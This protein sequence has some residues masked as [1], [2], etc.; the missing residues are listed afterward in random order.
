MIEQLANSGPLPALEMAIRFAAGRQRVIAHNI[1]NISTPNFQPT[2]V[3]PRAF[4][5]VLGEAIDARRGRTGGLD[6]DLTWSATREIAPAGRSTSRGRSSDALELTAR[7]DSDGVLVHDR[8][9]RDVERL[10]Q[11]NAENAAVFRV[12]TEL[13]R[14]HTTMLNMAISERA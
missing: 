1:A 9:N 8:N 3:S 10:M 12:A 2:D 6:G 7:T 13:R 14:Q 5:K 11:A 4:Q